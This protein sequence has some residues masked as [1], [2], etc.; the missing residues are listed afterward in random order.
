VKWAIEDGIVT[1]IAQSA[2]TRMMMLAWMNRDGARNAGRRRSA[3]SLEPSPPPQKLGHK[4]EGVGPV[5]QLHQLRLDCDNDVVLLEVSSSATMARIACQP[6][7]TML[8]QKR[9]RRWTPV[10]PVEDPERYNEHRTHGPHRR[11]DQSRKRPRRLTAAKLLE[12]RSNRAP[13]RS[14]EGCEEATET[15]MSGKAGEARRCHDGARPWFQS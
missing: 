2:D 9:G 1:V 5:P 10:E 7:A 14:E 8:F 11:G 12:R 15:V 4:G 6:G 3:P 13:Q